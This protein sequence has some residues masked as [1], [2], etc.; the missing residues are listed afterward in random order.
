ME[1][2]G[3][4]L[5]PMAGVWK[6]IEGERGETRLGPLLRFPLRVRRDGGRILLLYKPPFS[7][8][9]DEISPA[10]PDLWLGRATLGGLPVG[11]FRMVRMGYHERTQP[12]R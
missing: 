1:R 6:R 8:L 2:L 5:P 9:V 7:A 10:G 12:R 11:R 3:G 4:L